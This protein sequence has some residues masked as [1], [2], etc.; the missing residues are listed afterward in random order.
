MPTAK[1]LHERAKLKPINII[2]H[3]RAKNIW[4]KIA[5]G[6]AG[7]QDTYNEIDGIEIVRPHKWFPSS[8]ARARMAA[9][10]PLYV[11]DDTQDPAMR[12]YY[13]L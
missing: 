13:D 2:L 7:D 8:L 10:P 4:D 5:A 1:Y 9:P 3:L 11:W 6:T 12:A